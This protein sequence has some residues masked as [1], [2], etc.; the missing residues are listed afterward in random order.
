[1]KTGPWFLEQ[2]EID[3]L[4][5]SRDVLKADAKTAAEEY[6]GHI[7]GNWVDYGFS[8]ATN[9]CAVCFYGVTVTAY[10]TPNPDGIMTF[11]KAVAFKCDRK[12]DNMKLEAA[13]ESGA[14]R[15]LREYGRALRQ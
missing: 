10:L 8:T 7:L 1:M 12:E 9:Y 4:V 2:A 14:K 6:Y 3:Q 5:S 15:G 11:G 13:K